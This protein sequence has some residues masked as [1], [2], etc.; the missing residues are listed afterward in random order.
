MN[1][2]TKHN[3]AI[4]LLASGKRIEETATMVSVT[5]RAVYNWLDDADFSDA[6]RKRQSDYIRRLNTKLI[7][8]NE[9]ALDVLS[10]G[11]DSRDESIRIRCASIVTGKYH[12]TVEF[13]DILQRIERIEKT[14]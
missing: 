13:E 3:Q 14:R 2:K 12:K 11:L 5:R 4:E 1:L 9:K 10:A 7:T 6:L 8:L